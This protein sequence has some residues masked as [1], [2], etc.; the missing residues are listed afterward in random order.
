MGFL[1]DMSL[2][3]SLIDRCL[4]GATNSSSSS[5]I[6]PNKDSS[7][8][9]KNNEEDIRVTPSNASNDVLSGVCPPKTYKHRPIESYFCPLLNTSSKVPPTAKPLR[10]H[11]RQQHS[12]GKRDMGWITHL[13]QLVRRLQK[14]TNNNRYWNSLGVSTNFNRRACGIKA[15]G[16]AMESIELL[17]RCFYPR[18]DVIKWK[19]V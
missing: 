18:Q 17:R 2:D 14:Y 5:M 6:S 10:I 19:T 9:F 8:M 12:G 11:M 13:V 7:V 4:G 16:T 15:T 1:W 3:S